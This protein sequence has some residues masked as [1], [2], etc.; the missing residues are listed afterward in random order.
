MV[1]HVATET[2]F[3]G[4]DVCE[5][6]SSLSVLFALNHHLRFV[7]KIRLLN[8]SSKYLTTPEINVERL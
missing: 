5:M 1:T 4:S 7:H 8:G 3:E 2:T 6:Q